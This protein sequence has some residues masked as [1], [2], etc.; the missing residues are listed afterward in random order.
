MVKNDTFLQGKR[1]KQKDIWCTILGA[2]QFGLRAFRKRWGLPIAFFISLN[3]PLDILF[4]LTAKSQLTKVLSTGL[5][6]SW[7]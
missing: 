7:L 1:E 5:L 3:P 6:I 4:I 2:T